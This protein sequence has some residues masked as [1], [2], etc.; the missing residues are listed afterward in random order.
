MK[1]IRNKYLNNK[2][3]NNKKFQDVL[4]VLREIRNQQKHQK[5]LQNI[6]KH[7]VHLKEF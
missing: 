1:P 3:L 7:A 5:R 4:H 6:V 2:N